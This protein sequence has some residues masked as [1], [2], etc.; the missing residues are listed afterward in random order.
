MVSTLA[1]R[2]DGSESTPILGYWEIRGTA[3]PIRYMLNYLGVEYEEAK[4]QMGGPPDYDRSSWTLKKDK[5]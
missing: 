2:D 4:Y 1:H 3:Q 5:L